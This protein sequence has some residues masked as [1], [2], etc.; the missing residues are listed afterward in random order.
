MV[1]DGDSGVALPTGKDPGQ[2][3]WVNK[4]V[5]VERLSAC[6]LCSL[7]R[8]AHT[9][10]TGSTRQSGIYRGSAEQAGWS[11]QLSGDGDA[12]GTIMTHRQR[13]EQNKYSYVCVLGSGKEGGCCRGWSSTKKPGTEL[14]LERQQVPMAEGKHSEERRGTGVKQ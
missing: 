4:T 13:S 7:R 6:S 8:G 11:P 12:N 10:R 3:F 5:C 9:H 14:T 1:P 2:P